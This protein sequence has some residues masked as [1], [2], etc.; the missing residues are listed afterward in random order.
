M[1]GSYHGQPMHA[2]LLLPIEG[3]HFDHWRALFEATARE[4]CP[5]TAADH[6]SNRLGESLKALNSGSRAPTVYGS[7]PASDMCGGIV[8]LEQRPRSPLDERYPA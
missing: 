6:S 3:Q 1:S 4:T 5:Q 7:T 2:H 8:K